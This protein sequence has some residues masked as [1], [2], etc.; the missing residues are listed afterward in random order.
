MQHQP[1]AGVFRLVEALV[2]ASIRFV[3]FSSEDEFKARVGFVCQMVPFYCRLIIKCLLRCLLKKWD[4]K[5]D[6]I[7]IFH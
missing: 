1:R 5:L 7:A 4:L 3:H 6:G 2:G